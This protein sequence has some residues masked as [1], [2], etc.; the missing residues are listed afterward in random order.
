MEKSTSGSIKKRVEDSLAMGV[1]ELFD[2]GNEDHV[3]NPGAKL[4]LVVEIGKWEGLVNEKKALQDRKWTG[5]LL[6][7]FKSGDRAE[8][9][10]PEP[11][12]RGTR[13]AGRK[14]LA[15]ALKRFVFD[16]S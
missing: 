8:L 11:V 15:E 10:N 6:E 3:R 9:D 12:A 14:L 16:Q 13:S 1:I 4:N 2:F 5:S 7:V